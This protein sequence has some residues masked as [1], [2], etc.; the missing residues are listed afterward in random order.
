MNHTC[1]RIINNLALGLG[2]LFVPIR[3]HASQIIAWGAGVTNSGQYPDLGQSIV[4]ADLTNAI[5]IAGGE[6]F[7]L[8]LRSDG[9]VIAWGDNS[10]GQT[11]VPAD[12]T[13]VAAIA[14]GYAHALAL[15]TDGT[16]IAWGSNDSQ[17][18]N[19]PPDLTNAVAIAA[20]Q[21]HSLAL[22]SDG[23]VMAWGDNTANQTHVP[24]VLSNVVAIATGRSHSLALR[25]DG[26]VIAW[27]DNSS[28][29][30][31]PPFGLNGVIGIAA[32]DSY[33]LA[34]K[35]NGTVIA[36]G[37]QTNVP[38]SLAIP[39]AAI[40]S[41]NDGTTETAVNKV[42]AQD[43]NVV[44]NGDK[45][46]PIVVD[47][48]PGLAVMANGRLNIDTNYIN[49][50]ASAYSMTNYNTINEI[51]DYTAQG[52]ANALFDFNRLAAVADATP[53]GPSASRNNHFTNFSDFLKAI[54]NSTP[55]KPLYGVVVADVTVNDATNRNFFPLLQTLA[56]NG[57]NVKGTLLFNCLGPG[58]DLVNPK[59]MVLVDFNINP[60][61][62]SQ[63]VAT[64]P[65]TYTTGY[66]PTYPGTNSAFNPVNIN[67]EPA[68]Q[69]F[70]TSD[71]LPA[72]MYTTGGLDLHGNA[73]ISGMMYTP[74]YIEIE[75]LTSGNT[76]YIRGSVIMGNG[77]YYQNTSAGSTSIISCDSKPRPRGL[78]A[79][80]GHN[81]AMRVDG[82]VFS[83]GNLISQPAG[84]TNVTAIAA[85]VLHDLAL[86]GDPTLALN[87]LLGN[88]SWSSQGFTIPVP[89]RSGR[90][91]SLEYKNTLSDMN[92]TAL[93]LVAGNGRLITLVDPDSS[94]PQRFYRVLQW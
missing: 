29:Q 22:R 37:S 59:I 77:I 66:P 67:I 49:P 8:A 90:V 18:T 50:P 56:P 41:V 20:G 81:L 30:S 42:A 24:T 11:N 31:A 13:N 70:T 94:R 36:W 76:Q 34:L 3:S 12:L 86:E 32:G 7:S 14:A 64:N 40:I 93:P 21:S 57:I 62:L 55:A 92:W 33:S 10:L 79:C 75:N 52:S 45:S 4:P 89:T 88:A 43:G 68:Y 91:Y 51:P 46:A 47:G 44:V 48:G 61:N 69:N 25:S 83:W 65:A 5:A 39:A 63:L 54:S 2:L 60:A 17:Q 38:A 26:K 28:G 53:N 73:N 15:K 74:S 58:W 72:V 27:G 1:L 85:G 71:D 80:F 23:I 16:V 87:I 84:L 9:T 35:A 82:T 6:T 19:V 78:A